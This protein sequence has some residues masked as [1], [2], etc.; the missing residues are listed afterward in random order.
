MLH[1]LRIII[2]GT[3]LSFLVACVTPDQ[4]GNTPTPPQGEIGKIIGTPPNKKPIVTGFQRTG[5]P[6][7]AIMNYSSGIITIWAVAPNNWLWGYSPFDSQGFGDLRHWFILKNADGSVSF[8]NSATGTCIASHGN[9]IVHIDCNRDNPKQQFDLL[10]LTNGAVALKNV[11][12]QLCLRTPIFRSTVY[13]SLTFANCV[14][15]N[16]N[17]LDQQWFIIPPIEN[18]NPIPLLPPSTQG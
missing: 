14:K 7:I 6:K 1:Q 5:E 18:A 9:G 10:S 16:Q 12:N 11:D 2:T 4:L 13:M 8:R 17:T 15:T 3:L